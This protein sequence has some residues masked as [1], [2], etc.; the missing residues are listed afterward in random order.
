MVA[1]AAVETCKMSWEGEKNWGFS[2]F[3]V[4]WLA[5]INVAQ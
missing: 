4:P 5:Q 1:A 3:T 2:V